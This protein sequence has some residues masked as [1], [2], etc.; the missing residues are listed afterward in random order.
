MYIRLQMTTGEIRLLTGKFCKRDLLLCLLLVVTTLFVFPVTATVLNCDGPRW[1]NTSTVLVPMDPVA[2]R[3]VTRRGVIADHQT[4]TG[5][6]RQKVTTAAT[7]S[8]AICPSN[9][10]RTPPCPG[11]NVPESLAPNLRFSA[12]SARSP[13]CASKAATTDTAQT[14]GK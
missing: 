14:C 13:P 8:A 10:S 4:K 12:L 3:I 6:P 11:S 9:R 2:P 7:S 1:R 5:C